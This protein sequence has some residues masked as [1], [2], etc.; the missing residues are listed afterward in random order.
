[1]NTRRVSKI[2]AVVLVVIFSIYVIAIESGISIKKQENEISNSYHHIVLNITRRKAIT[3]PPA[4]DGIKTQSHDYE[5]SIDATRNNHK[6]VGIIVSIV[7]IV[8]VVSV[9]RMLV[10]YEHSK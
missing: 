5:V 2:T 10:K 6:W 3:W 4:R 1:M 9:L 7:L 8:G